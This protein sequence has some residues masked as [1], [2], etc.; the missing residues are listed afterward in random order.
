VSVIEFFDYLAAHDH[1]RD[2]AGELVRAWLEQARN[3]SA[4]PA[5]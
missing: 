4:R 1:T 2:L 5:A 3:S